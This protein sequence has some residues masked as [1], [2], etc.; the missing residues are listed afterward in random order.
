MSNM[1]ELLKEKLVGNTDSHPESF[2]DDTGIDYK[3]VAEVTWI[4][5]GKYSHGSYL[6]SVGDE[7]F[8]LSVSRSGSYH[9]D[10]YY[11]IC[12]ISQYTPDT[13]YK[14]EYTFPS[15]GVAQQFAI[16]MCGSGEQSMWQHAEDSGAALNR[17]VTYDYNAGSLEIG[18]R[19]N[20]E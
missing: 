16:W 2:L 3:E 10:Y 14:V 18:K 12:E 15:Q 13:R 4:D 20:E 9:T 1:L 17:K 8:E 7:H 19:F 5:E 6:F 11:D